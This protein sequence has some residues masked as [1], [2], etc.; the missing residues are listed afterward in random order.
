M[1]LKK[2][3]DIIVVGGGP[4]GC[5]AAYTAAQKDVSVLL[6]EK[7]RD[8]GSPVRCAEAVGKDGLEKILGNEINSQWIAAT[9]KKFKFVAPDRTIIYPQVPMTGYVLHRKLFDFDLGVMAA[10]AGSTIITKACVTDLIRKDDY[11]SGVRVRLN[12]KDQVINGKIIIGADGVES[13]VARWAGIDTTVPMRDMETCAQMTLSNL[14]VDNDTCVFY[15]SQEKFPGGYGW[16]FPKGNN[17]ANVGLGISGDKAR[18]DS[19]FSRLEAFIQDEFPQASIMNKTIGGVPC[20]N[21]I[22]Q[23]SSDRILLVGDAALQA[24]PVSGGGIATGMTA[25]KIAGKVAAEAIKAGD[26]SAGFLKKYEKEWDSSC[27]NAQKRYYRLKEGIKKLSDDQLNKTAFALKDIPKE[28]QTLV[29][30]FQIALTK[31]P[32][33]LIDIVKT[34]S[35]FS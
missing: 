7:D 26:Y 11:L 13:R 24:N 14:P 21:R 5:I 10:R 6:L 23:L 31:Q 35:P 22:S 25:G 18:S 29:K 9:I 28:K 33:L 32:G 15:F 19:A 2:D 16:V 20:G 1:N 17:T 12:G 4:A 30:I 34:L 27:G 3:Y 8:I